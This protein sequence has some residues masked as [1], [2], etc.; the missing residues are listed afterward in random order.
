VAFPLGADAAG[1]PAGRPPG[2][3]AIRVPA[4]LIH[5]RGDACTSFGSA[6]VLRGTLTGAPRAALLALDARPQ[7]GERRCGRFAAHGFNGV[8]DAAVAAIVAWME[9]H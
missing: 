5:S 1:T 2:M 6:Q 9:R 8:E 3:A 7:P 4:L